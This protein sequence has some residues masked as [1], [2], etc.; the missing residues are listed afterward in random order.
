MHTR[1]A[2]V[3]KKKKKHSQCNLSQNDTRANTVNDILQLSLTSRQ[4]Y[5]RT[6]TF[7]ATQRNKSIAPS[8]RWPRESR[9]QHDLFRLLTLHSCGSVIGTPPRGETRLKNSD[10]QNQRPGKKQKYDTQLTAHLIGMGSCGSFPSLLSRTC[11]Q[12][13]R[14]SR[15]RQPPSGQM[16]TVDVSGHTRYTFQGAH[17]NIKMRQRHHTATNRHARERSDTA[18]WR[19]LVSRS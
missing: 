3:S 9:G 18:G 15:M 8:K 5:F 10:M 12:S 14:D 11:G 13:P 4:C 1:I 6:T 7:C 16:C 17:R 19:R 2:L